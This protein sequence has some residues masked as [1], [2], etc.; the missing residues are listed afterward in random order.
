MAARINPCANYTKEYEHDN[1]GAISVIFY[2][3]LYF[4]KFDGYYQI[5]WRTQYEKCFQMTAAPD[6]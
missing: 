3:R 4:P 5:E 6:E 1:M 2:S